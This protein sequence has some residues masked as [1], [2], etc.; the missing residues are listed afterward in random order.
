MKRGIRQQVELG[1]FAEHYIVT[2]RE[3]LGMIL[4]GVFI[5]IMTVILWL[6]VT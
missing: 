5:G 2:G 4:T 6:A 1:R 3:I